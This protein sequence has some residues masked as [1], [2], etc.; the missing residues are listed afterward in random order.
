MASSVA[1]AITSSNIGYCHYFDVL[2]HLNCHHLGFRRTIDNFPSC[3][4][5][6]VAAATM[7]PTFEFKVIIVNHLKGLLMQS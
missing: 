1:E 2:L 7:E 5:Q 4:G 3:S 6:I